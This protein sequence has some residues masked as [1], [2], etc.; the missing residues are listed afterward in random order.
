MSDLTAEEVAAQNEALREGVLQ[1]GAAPD[2]E[3]FMTMAFVSLP[4]IPHL[5]ITT[6]GLIDVDRQQPVSLFADGENEEKT[7]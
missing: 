6:L 3:A 4:V 5:K 7:R 2:V 1:L